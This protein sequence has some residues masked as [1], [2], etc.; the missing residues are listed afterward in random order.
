MTPRLVQFLLVAIIGGSAIAL[1]ALFWWA[2]T[3]FTAGF[4]CG[5]LLM[6]ICGRLIYGHWMGDEYPPASG[7]QATRPSQHAEEPEE[8]R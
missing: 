6:L 4:F 3:W 7:S 2:G 5:A 8:W 1:L